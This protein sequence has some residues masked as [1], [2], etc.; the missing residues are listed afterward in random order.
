MYRESVRTVLS[1]L[2]RHTK[3][4]MSA[5]GK[6]RAEMGKGDGENGKKNGEG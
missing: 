3:G 6:A 4:E 2:G 1:L 5:N